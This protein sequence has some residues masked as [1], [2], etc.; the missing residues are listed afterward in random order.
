MTT[1]SSTILDVVD[2]FATAAR[3]AD[4]AALPGKQLKEFG[5]EVRRY[6]QASD[7]P[8]MDQSQHPSY[9]GGWPSA[10]FGTVA[11]D[12][13]LSNLLYSG[14]I[15]VK[16]PLADWFCEEQYHVENK[17]SARPGYRT[18]DG[19]LTIGE[20][21]AYLR[22][23]LPAL[24]AL[25]PLIKAG[26]VVLAPSQPLF[27]REEAAITALREQLTERLARDL[28]N[29]LGR[30]SPPDVPLD[31]NRRGMFLW[32]GGSDK[33]QQYRQAVSSG[34]LYFAREYSLAAATGA[35]YTAAFPHEQFVAREGLTEPDSPSSRVVEALFQSQL[36]VF[37]GLTPEVITEL[38]DDNA[39]AGFRA[40]LHTVYQGLPNS[41]D[42]KD[43]AG[44]VQDQENALLMPHL[45]GAEKAAGAGRLGRVAGLAKDVTF[46]LGAGLLVDLA[47]ETPA[48]GVATSAAVTLAQTIRNGTKRD[49]S[50]QVI[51]NALVRHNR[52]VAQELRGVQEQPRSTVTTGDPW[53][54]PDEASMSVTVSTGSLLWLG[55]PPSNANNAK[56]SKGY[57]GG[58]YR[59]CDCGSDEK[60]KFCCMGI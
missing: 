27:L 49:G 55:L 28:P 24:Q 47:S 38:H 51:W 15:L 3:V 32:V 6:T 8:T 37:R 58:V 46:S 34:M 54:I 39:F 36:P 11:G 7:L 16:D 59:P 45:L 42:P 43:I 33:E 40:Q 12:M 13:L 50:P 25:R 31:D 20:T 60:F 22:S 53:A 26:I 10:N 4:I 23:I 19:S 56:P 44:Y 48:L 57:G 5:E 21:R 30:F 35:V 41:E 14:Q 18:E 29:Y 2:N 9:L 1:P 17:L 52:K